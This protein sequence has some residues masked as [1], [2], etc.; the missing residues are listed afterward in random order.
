M[1]IEIP[2]GYNNGTHIYHLSSF[3]YLLDIKSKSCYAIL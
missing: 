2:N 3:S 1:N